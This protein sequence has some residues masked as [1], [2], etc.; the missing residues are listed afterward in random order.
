MKRTLLLLGIMIITLTSFAA[1]PTAHAKEP[2]ASKTAGP[3]GE[4]YV[5][6]NGIVLLVKE[7]HALP[8]VMVNMI[9]KAGAV[10]E[11]ADKNGL[12]HL[13][14]GLLMKGAAKKSAT[15]ISEAI[16]FVGGS[17]STGGGM[18]YSTAGLTVL[19]KDVDTGFSLL[20]EVLMQPTFDQAEIDRLKKEVKAG[21]IRGEQ[22]PEVVASKA[23]AKAVFGEAHPYGRPVEGTLDSLDKISREDIKSFHERLYAPNNAIMA[24]VGDITADEAKALIGKYMQ[25]WQKKDVPPPVFPS[26]PKPEGVKLIKTDRDITQA[27]IIMGH[28]GIKREDPDYYSLYIMNYILG[29]GGF[30]SR[31]LDKI[32]DDMGL[33]YDVHSYFSA[34][35]YDGSFVVGMETK[36]STAKTAIDEADKI[37]ETMRTQPVTDSEIQDAKDYI[38]GSFPRRMDTNSKIAELLAQVE[39]FNLGLDYFDMYEREITK[40]TKEDVLRVA[41]KYLHPNNQYVVVVGN[42]KEAGMQ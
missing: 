24:V 37:I 3:I 21:I 28:P 1:A 17:L 5:L 30:V 42:L 15:E 19:K 35:K 23:F 27:N 4:R 14:A 2:Q 40:V 6:D 20:S 34:S 41:K 26:L 32:R 10:M 18:D 25:G 29:G 12:A 16:E 8:V 33:A 9:I 39:F 38:T 13:T 7:N 31:L 36:N 11:P 22:E